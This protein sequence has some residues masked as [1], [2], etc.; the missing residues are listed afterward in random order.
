MAPRIQIDHALLTAPVG[1]KP[2]YASL[3]SQA[4]AGGLTTPV[5]TS[6]LRLIIH[7]LVDHVAVSDRVPASNIHSAQALW[8][9]VYS[10]TLRKRALP[11]PWKADRRAAKRAIA[12]PPHLLLL[13]SAEGNKYARLFEMQALDGGTALPLKRADDV[14]LVAEL[15][16]SSCG[17]ERVWMQ[18]VEAAVA[19]APADGEYN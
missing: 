13:A 15:V 17:L 1:D 3:V 2:K 10:S 16:L 11:T 5:S 14:A 18:H 12:L 6:T 19:R 7:F 4:K 8:M 9:R